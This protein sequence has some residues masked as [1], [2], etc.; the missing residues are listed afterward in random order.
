[1]G[2]PVRPSESATQLS[3]LPC[4]L[5]CDPNLLDRGCA[6]VKFMS[7]YIY[8]YIYIYILKKKMAVCRLFACLKNLGFS[9][10]W[11]PILDHVGSRMG[12]KWFQH[13]PNMGPMM[14]PSWSHNG[15]LNGPYAPKHGSTWAKHGPIMAHSEPILGPSSAHNVPNMGPHSRH[16]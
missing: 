16:T 4:F 12:P 5:Q 15:K 1:L 14:G 10:L 2:S 9:E 8:I 13:G 3:F 7:I 6:G 11:F